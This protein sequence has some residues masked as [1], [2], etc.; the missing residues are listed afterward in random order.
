LGGGEY[1][2]AGNEFHSGAAFLF[3]NHGIL[4][5]SCKKCNNSIQDINNVTL[6]DFAGLQFIDTAA[7]GKLCPSSGSDVKI[8]GCFWKLFL[9]WYLAKINFLGE[10]DRV[11]IKAPN[12]LQICDEGK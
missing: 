3:P 8:E 10:V 4:T 11:Y 5:L 2:P 1:L 6:R 7:D 12:H 9:S